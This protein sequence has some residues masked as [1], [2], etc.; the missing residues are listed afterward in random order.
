[1]RG[2]AQ[3]PARRGCHPPRIRAI[4]LDGNAEAGRV[5]K[6]T[7]LAVAA[8]VATWGLAAMSQA[9]GAAMPERAIASNGAVIEMPAI[10]RLDCAGMERVLRLIDL[11]GYRGPAPLGPEDADWP[12][13]DYEDRLS[14]VHYFGC[15][16]ERYR[17]EDPGP[18]FAFGF[19]PQ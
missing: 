2:R 1:M 13:F 18:A 16:V 11:A 7:G 10:E 5:V 4:L 12:I 9:A 19:E 6:S 17:L 3:A 15:I 14:R 8:T